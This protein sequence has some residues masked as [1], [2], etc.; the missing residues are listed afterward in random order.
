MPIEPTEDTLSFYV[1]YTSQ[2][3]RPTS[4]ANYLSGICNQLEPFFPNVRAARRSQLVSR[5]M[6]GCLKLHATAPTWKSPLLRSQLSTVLLHYAQSTALDDLLF[7]A[8]LATAFHGL[9]CLG[10]L[11]WPDTLALHDW[12]RVIVR[13]SL[14]WMPNGYRFLLPTSKTDRTYRGHDILI[15]GVPSACDPVRPFRRYLIERDRLFPFHPNLWTRTS[16]D[17]PTRAWFMRRLRA[18]FPA[19]IS[20]HSLRAGGATALA[21]DGIPLDYIQFLVCQPYILIKYK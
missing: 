20:G 8:L 18:H 1:V 19:D 6:R 21:E 3:I 2:H 9:L 15:A 14:Q 5:T 16:G 13:N 17:V 7:A 4:V 12:Q 11:V 10:E